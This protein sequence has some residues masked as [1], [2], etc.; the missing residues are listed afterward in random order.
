MSDLEILSNVIGRL[1]SISVPVQYTEQITIPLIN[2]NNLLKQLYKAIVDQ[3]KAKEEPKPE[4]KDDLQITSIEPVDENE[5][6]QDAE[7]LK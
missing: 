3:L 2:A 7:E 5:V 1:D 4:S 6:P